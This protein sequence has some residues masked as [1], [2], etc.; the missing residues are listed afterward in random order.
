MATRVAPGAPSPASRLLG[1]AGEEEEA[2]RGR[3]ADWLR[4]A[5]VDEIEPEFQTGCGPVGMYLV[6]R[7]I[8]IDV[9]RGTGPRGA[10]SG[11]R[12]GESALRQISG[13][14]ESERRRERLLF[15]DDAGAGMSWIGIV[16][17]G[18]RWWA[19]EWQKGGADGKPVPQ[20]QGARLD[21]DNIG[22]LEGMVTRG[23]AGK[24]WIPPD[25]SALFDGFFAEL[26]AL[27][28]QVGDSP[29]TREQKGI[30]LEQLQDGG[31]APTS[32]TDGVFVAHTLLVLISRMVSIAASKDHS[33]GFPE[34][35]TDGFV[36]WV[37]DG[38]GPILKK[39]HATVNEYDWVR[40]PGD[41]LRALYS[42]FVGQGHRKAFGEYYTPDWLAEMICLE[43]IDD[44]YISVQ[45][46]AFRGG[47]GADA[48]SCVLDPT[49]GSGTFLYSA[50]RR[51]LESAALERSPMDSERKALFV[52]SMVCGVDMHPVA[53]EMARANVIRAAPMAPWESVSVCR[54]DALLGGWPCAG[55]P[56]PTWP[57]TQD[58]AGRPGAAQGR[59]R[60]KRAGRIVSNPPWVT[61]QEIQDAGRKEEVRRMA[62]GESIW[63]GSE[64]APRFDIAG[65]FVKRCVSLYLGG[66]RSAWVLPQGAAVS[67]KNW[68]GF[69]AAM[70]GKIAEYWDLKRLPFPW[71]P[72]CV[73]ITGHGG[74]EITRTYAKRGGHK[75][76]DG[77]RWA[78]ARAKIKR[79]RRKAFT[80]RKSRW[81]DSEGRLPVRHGAS[82][83]P[84]PLIRIGRVTGVSGGITSF[85]THASHKRPWSGLGSLK[86]A[87]PSGYVKD[88]II[89]TYVFPFVARCNKTIIPVEGGAWDPGRK[90]SGYW[91]DACA[92]YEKNRGVGP[93][94]PRTLE[95][96]IDHNGK[97]MRQLGGAG[98][99]RVVYNAVGDV[100]YAA[101]IGAGVIGGVGVCVVSADTASEALF[102]AGILNAPC[103]LDAYLSTRRSDRNFHLHFW[104]A[105]PIPRYDKSDGD[106]AE[107]AR[108]ARRAESIASSVKLVDS[109]LKSKGLIRG[110][111]AGVLGEIDEV[112]SR[113]LPDYVEKDGG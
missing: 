101:R 78:S 68:G 113:I 86:G 57:A 52:A 63:V 83:Q 69:R 28:S 53:V 8:M 43:A 3:I 35:V 64:T 60:G 102:L 90:N 59:P 13:H 91:R 47:D 6:N 12:D 56:Y 29:P 65:L 76:G 16:T 74:G 77:D 103:L 107:L 49:C 15:G 23:K 109:P 97:L 104:G 18:G 66:G 22:G 2:I 79:V 20:W 46:D 41:V 73:A 70:E 30:W 72:A 34:S 39:L 111:L 5:G 58:P 81:L 95:D 9:K 96:C 48:L 38:G 82:L 105:I 106:H 4:H 84:A 100:L 55:P 7:R 92:L 87:V 17:D 50:A 61:L 24:R 71:T 93:S 94:N 40:R 45:V 112:A 27:L 80:A 10:R 33:A 31:N 99:H 21:R 25:P 108:L 14:V 26:K 75:I 1:A 67:G 110:A 88:T 89:S 32:D 44:D 11:P 51:I 36:G 98:G 54:G 19:W 37:G 85:E 62:H 42:H